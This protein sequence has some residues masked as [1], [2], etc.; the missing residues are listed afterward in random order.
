ML[1]LDKKLVDVKIHEPRMNVA[2]TD[3]L[4]NKGSVEVTFKYDEVSK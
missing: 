2:L 4:K 3:E 1:F